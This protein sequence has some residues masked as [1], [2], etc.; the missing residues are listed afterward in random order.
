MRFIKD[1]LCCDKDLSA[2]IIR[3]LSRFGSMFTAR[4]LLL[5]R[6]SVPNTGLRAGNEAE[7]T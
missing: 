7:K 5:R 1:V 6:D 3:C 2:L 4:Q